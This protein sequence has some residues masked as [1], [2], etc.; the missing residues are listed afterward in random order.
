MISSSMARSLVWIGI[1]ATL[2]FQGCG[3]SDRPPLGYVT[4]TVT[5]D[6]MPLEGVIVTFKPESGRPGVGTTDSKGHYE[7]KYTNAVKGTKV[8]P[9]TVVFMAQTGI[10]PSH[11]IPA[12]Y[13]SGELYKVDVKSHGNKLD[14][15]LESDG[16]V[17]KPA[18]KK[19]IVAD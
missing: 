4:G 9:S 2:C 13:Q 5:I 12:R 11:P 1:G 10:N 18:V 17:A 16:K 15:D 6:G 7:L 8:G 19:G 14:F 3:S